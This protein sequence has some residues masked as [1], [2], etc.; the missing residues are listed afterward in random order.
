MD[1]L[2]STRKSL[3]FSILGLGLLLTAAP[4]YFT[5][6]LPTDCVVY[7]PDGR[8]VRVN[9]Q[10]SV[11]PCSS[12]SGGVRP[13]QSRPD[14]R[15]IAL[16]IAATRYEAVVRNVA[17][18]FNFL[19][20]DSWLKLPHSTEGD[21]YNA[22]NQLHK[23]LLNEAGANRFRA[24][25][26]RKELAYLENSI[27]S[28]PGMIEDLNAEIANLRSKNTLLTGELSL[29]QKKVELTRTATKQ[30][31]KLTAL[32]QAEAASNRKATIAAF[33]VLLPQE[34]AKT[35]KPGP[36]QSTL[37]WTPSVP[38][39]K[40]IPQYPSM[41]AAVVR[42]ERPGPVFVEIRPALLSGDPANAAE[43]LESDVEAVIS[44]VNSNNWELSTKVNAARD[45]VEPL[46][47]TRNNLLNARTSL[48]DGIES[49]NARIMEIETVDRLIASDEL[50][51]S[52]Q[53]FLYRTANALIWKS[54]KSWAL[55]AVKADVKRLIAAR[56]LNTRY[57]DL[58][59]DQILEFWQAGKQNI[60]GLSTKAI[61][62]QGKIQP[63]LNA[64]R[65]LQTEGEGYMLDAARLAALGTP[66]EIESFSIRLNDGLDRDA[67]E[68]V[69]ADLG[70][71]SIPEPWKTIASKYFL[72]QVK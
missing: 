5:Q 44:A 63:I 66:R 47:R 20:R 37:E 22:V 29:V 59:E 35:A 26:L 55:K 45:A 58:S 57:R 50:K 14:P 56:S 41:T 61:S 25:Q 38:E 2:G 43:V 9:C 51:A 65:T 48:K 28:L 3:L 11:D 31:D 46:A 49:A 36:Y 18:R 54:A 40:R 10:T 34:I 69:K 53:M 64:I 23:L 4:E 32:Y 17:G 21:F 39:R 30:L 24:E 71:L 1:I 6:S 27:K 60:F 15:Q 19:D 42:A 70:A 16:E 72:R 62:A 33:E 67:Q 68:L 7:C 52:E 12:V 8:K 13:G